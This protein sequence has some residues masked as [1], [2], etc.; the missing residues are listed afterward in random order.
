MWTEVADVYE[1][2]V[3]P[4]VIV[5]VHTRS[6]SLVPDLQKTRDGALQ[7]GIAAEQMLGG[8]RRNRDNDDK[9]DM[10]K[11]IADV[12]AARENDGDDSGNVGITDDIGDIDLCGDPAPKKV[13]QGE[14]PEGGDRIVTL[15]ELGIVVPPS[16]DDVNEDNLM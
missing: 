14:L 16:F 15:E 12:S 4:R 6:R 8:G 11:A 2:G 1:S 10:R 5:E 13:D 9:D 3:A 7:N